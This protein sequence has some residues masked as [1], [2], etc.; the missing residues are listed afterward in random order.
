MKSGGRVHG[1]GEAGG[2]GGA[3]LADVAGVGAGGRVDQQ[4]PP[5]VHFGPEQFGTLVALEPG[6][7]VSGEVG[8]RLFLGRQLH[9]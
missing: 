5:K 3:D 1:N 8:E 6:R 4:V 7:E 2:G 9:Y